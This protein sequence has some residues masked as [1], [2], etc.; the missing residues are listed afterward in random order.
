MKW[1]GPTNEEVSVRATQWELKRYNN[2]PN[3][4]LSKYQVRNLKNIDTVRVTVVNTV[5][6]ILGSTL[7]KKKYA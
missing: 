6:H 2:N 4:R 3:S 5:Q 1:K 7:S